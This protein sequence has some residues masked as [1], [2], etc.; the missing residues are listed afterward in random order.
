MELYVFYFATMNRVLLLSCL[1]AL[2][3]MAHAQFY[4]WGWGPPMTVTQSG[5]T[6]TCSVFDPVLNQTRT[7]DLFSVATWSYD[8]GVVATVSPAGTVTAMVYDIFLADFRDQQVGSNPGN[9]VVNSDGVVAFVSSAGTVGAAIYSPWLHDWRAS[10]LGSN[11]GNSIQNRD[12]VVSYVSSAGTVGA[13]VY[14]AALDDWRASQLGSNPG[15]TVQNRDGIVAWVSDAGTIGAAVY[16]PAQQQWQGSQLSSNPGNI[17]VIGQGV[18]AWRSDAGTIGGAAYDRYA[19]QWDEQQ[20]DSN[21]SNSLPTITDGTVEW[22]NN[23]GLQRYGYT[24]SQNWQSD[25]NTTTQCV[26]FPVSVGA[27]GGFYVA[28]LHCLSIGASSYSHQCGDGHLITRRWAWKAYANPGSY[29]PELSAFSS[30]S[31]STCNGNLAFAGVGVEELSAT[32]ALV[33]SAY[34]GLLTVSSDGPLGQVTVYDAQG[35][36]IAGT[37]TANTQVTIPLAV[38]TGYYRVSVIGASGGVRTKGVVVGMSE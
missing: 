2:T 30:T 33:V 6:I 7:Q 37:R 23:N 24:G 4:N 15:N 11:P 22:T 19:H 32:D 16:D 10:Q 25:V 28:Y 21:G 9:T 35:R 1:A 14:D 34:H 13:A 12:G 5:T 38:A 27:G 8:D 29:S 18:V 3:A 17:L 31:N 26:Y 36:A 20:F